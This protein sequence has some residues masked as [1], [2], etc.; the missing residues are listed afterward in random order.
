MVDI[1]DVD[2]EGY[3]RPLYKDKEFLEYAYNELEL[4][5][6]EIGKV[7]GCSRRTAYL[8]VDKLVGTRTLSESSKIGNKKRNIEGKY[9]NEE[10]LREKYH[11]DHMTMKEIAELC[12]IGEKGI[13]YWFKK[14]DIKTRPKWESRHLRLKNRGPKYTDKEWLRE[15]YVNNERSINELAEELEVSKSTINL[16]MRHHSIPIRGHDEA[17]PSGKEHPNWN[18]GWENYYGPNWTEQREKALKNYNGKCAS[19]GIHREDY[20]RDLSVHHVIPIVNYWDDGELDYE[21]ANKVENLVP[22]CRNCHKIWEGIPVRPQANQ[23]IR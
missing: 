17:H 9:T 6:I 4:S 22:L 11:E 23:S 13:Q 15:E 7:A 18:G 1:A 14:F 21:S 19:C 5:T 12:S 2:T 10:W 3:D 20:D 8:W 16:W